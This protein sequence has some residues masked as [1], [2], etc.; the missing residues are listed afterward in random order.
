MD[1]SQF[2]ELSSFWTLYL[3]EMISV[4][5][6]FLFFDFHIVPEHLNLD[7]VDSSRPN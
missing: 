2:W 1:P 3:T 6:H 7:N 4:K 5:Y